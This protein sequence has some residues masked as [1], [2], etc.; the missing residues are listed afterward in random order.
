MQKP[1]EP[2]SS[3]E[4]LEQLRADGDHKALWTKALPLTKYAISGLIRSGRLSKE[5]SDDDFFQECCI[6]AGNA[7]RRWDPGR[8][9]FSR[10]VIYSV[11]N[12]ALDLLAGRKR[13]HYSYDDERTAGERPA[14]ESLL[15]KKEERT[16]IRAALNLMSPKYREMLER[17]YGIGRPE[18]SVADIARSLGVA[19]MSVHEMLVRAHKEMASCHQVTS[20][21]DGTSHVEKQR[22]SS[23]RSRS[24]R[25]AAARGEARPGR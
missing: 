6:A 2:R 18:E 24:S 8:A 10:W 20:I 15:S 25:T 23:V 4:A 13:F 14:V 11:R 12:A 1:A 22:R 7:V 9:S 3:K 21:G 17:R 19:R 16:A 5:Q